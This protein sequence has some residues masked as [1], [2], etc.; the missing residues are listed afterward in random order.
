MADIQSNIQVNID[1]SEAL[2]QLKALQ[3]QIST[4]HTS[5]AKN[6][7]QAARAQQDL[8]SNLINSIN[9]T[10]KFS[11]GIREIKSTTESFTDSLER[12]KLSTREYFRFAAGSTRT[13]GKLFKSEFD[14]IGKV[15][16]ERVKT[17]Q[18]QY[19]KM[20]RSAN[21]A[22]QSI[23]VRPL[24]L[25]MQDLSTKIALAAQKQ[26]LF[27]QLLKQGSTNLLNFGKNTQWAGRQ[28]MVGFTIPLTIF[29]T[30][31]SQ[32]FMDL[33]KQ[34]IRFKRVYGEI[35]TTTE[36]T[37]AALENI[38]LLADEFTKYGVAVVDTMKL[39]ADAA[40][41]GKMGAD[42]MAQ[43]TE[44]TRLAVLGSVEQS[45]A[46]STTIALQDAFGTSA[47]DLTRKINFLNA[48]ENQTV[49]SI[50]D[51]TIAIPKAGP[52]VKQLGGDVEDLAFFL[53]A[54]KEGGINA[55][56]GAN[57][58]KS[59]LAAL[60]NP[61]E[62]A[63][64]F[65]M[66]FGVNINSIVESNQG[67][68][69][70]I[71]L[72]FAA[73]LDTLDPL[74]RARAI[75]QLF[76]KFQFSRL[77]TLFQNVS[78][79][80]T[81]A[82]RVL[83][84]VS[85]STEELAIL[86]ERELKT[87][88]DATGTRFKK[89]M[90]NLKTAIAPVGEQ[91]LKAVTPIAEFVAKILEKFNGLGDGTKKALVIV[92]TVIGAIGPVFLMTFGL[93]AN[94]AANIIKL[95]GTMRN[96]FL[97]L[98]KQS[99]Q[100]AF[101]TQYMSS[102]QIEAA[103]IAASLN[104]AHSKL[105]QTFTL[106]SSA[107]DGLTNAYRRGVVAANNFAIAN[108]GMMGS[109]KRKK[110][111]AGGFVPGSGSGDTVPAMLTPGEFVVTKDAAQ[112][113]K[114]FLQGLNKGGFVLRNGG[115]PKQSQFVGG[116]VQTSGL[117][118]ISA[119]PTHTDG[120]LA[121]RKK[122]AGYVIAG[123]QAYN[124]AT[125][126][127]K[128][129]PYPYPLTRDDAKKAIQILARGPK[130]PNTIAALGALTDDY[131]TLNNNES[132]RRG[133]ATRYAL[134]G[135]LAAGEVKPGGP[136]FRALYGSFF[137]ASG[138]NTDTSGI[139]NSLM[140]NADTLW[141]KGLLSDKGMA[142]RNNKSKSA[143]THL[144]YKT[145]MSSVLAMLQQGKGP[146]D[147]ATRGAL[148][149]LIRVD[150]R[151][152]VVGA[153]QRFQRFAANRGFSIRGMQPPNFALARKM[154]TG[155]SV[156][157]YGEKDTVPAL[158]TPGEFVVNKK[159]TQ[160]N[161]PLL[162]A[163]NSGVPVKR[164][165]GT[166]SRSGNPSEGIGINPQSAENAGTKFSNVVERSLA[167]VSSTFANTISR[168]LLGS[169]RDALNNQASMQNPVS[170]LPSGERVSAGGI[171]IPVGVKDPSEDK[172]KQATKQTTKRRFGRFGRGGGAAGGQDAEAMRVRN[173]MMM[174]RANMAAFGLSAIAQGAS[175]MGGGI[176]DKVAPMMTAASGA[177]MAMSM[178][179]G[180][181]S[182]A[183]VGIGAIALAAVLVRRSF[184]KAQDE[185]LAF[186]EQMGASSKNIRMFAEAAGKVSA[187]EVMERRRKEKT[188]IYQIQ[189][190]KKTFGQAFAEGE[191]GKQMTK[192]VGK[193]IKQSGQ[194]GAQSALVS[195]MATAV[196]SGAMSAEQAR[197][198]VANIAQ[199]LGD[200]SFGMSVNAKLISILGPSGENL[201]TD[202]LT[203]RTKLIQDTRERMGQAS[204]ATNRSSK[205]TGMDMVKA[206]GWQAA[207]AGGGALAG[208]VVG[209]MI[210]PVVGTA[211]GAVVGAIGG[212]I[213]G[214]VYGR[215]DR[216]KRMGESSG[217][218]VALQKIA[219]EQQQE[220]L[221][222]MDLEYQRKIELLKAEGKISEAKK[223]QLEYD[224]NRQKL[225]EENQKTTEQITDSFATSKAQSQ[226]MTGVDKAITRKYKGTALEDVA[227]LSKSTIDD[228]EL[229]DEQ[230]FTLKMQ[231]AS[232]QLDPMQVLDIVDIFK[233][234]ED[235]EKFFKITTKFGGAVGSEALN[236]ASMFAG[237]DGTE[238]ELS[239]KIMFEVGA[240]PTPKEAQETIDFWNKITK[241]GGVL[242]V[243]IIGNV[244]SKDVDKQARLMD[245]FKQIDAKKGKIDVKIATKMF[246]ASSQAIKTL[247]ENL[248]YYNALPAEQQ[249]IYL[250]SLIT[251]TETV[252]TNGP[253]FQA[254]LK[255][256][257]ANARQM[258]Q[259]GFIESK[260]REFIHFKSQQLTKIAGDPTSALGGGGSGGGKER[261]TIFDD[262]LMRLKMVQDRSIKATGG[263]AELKRV[264]SGKGKISL[265]KFQGVDQQLLNNGKVSQE[266]LD[267][268]DALGPEGIQKDLKQ[269]VTIGKNGLMTLNEAGKVVLR[270]FVAAKLGEYEVSIKK[271]IQALNQQK[272]ATGAL[273]KA[274]FSYAEAQEL[275]KDQTLAL[276]LANNELTPK[277][278][279]SLRAK[280]Q[281]LTKAQLHYERVTKVALMDEM[282]GQKARFEMVQK[283]VAL[284]E[285]LIENQ[286]ASEK[287]ILTSRQ[288]G[289][290]YALEKISQEEEKINEKYD[291]QIESLDKIAAKQEEI[292]Q[293]QQRRFSL[294]QALAG[295]DMAGAAGA[296][297]EIRQA[298]AAAQIERKRKAIEDSRKKQLAGIEFGG[299]TREQ[300]EADNKAI[301][302]SLSDIEEK[303][304]LAKNALDDELKKTIGM[305]RVE[306]S[307]AVAGIGAALDAGI[308]PN[309]KDFL[310]KI[311]QGVIGNATDTVTALKA[312]GT[313]IK[314]LLALQEKEKEK[315]TGGTFEDPKIKAQREAEAAAKAA[316]LAAAGG[317]PTPTPTSTPPFTDH[318]NLPTTVAPKAADDWATQM[319]KYLG[320]VGPA[321]VWG[322]KQTTP[323]P[324]PAAYNPLNYLRTPY[325]SGGMVPKYMAMGGVVP[326]Y[327]AAGGYGKGTDTIPAM[328]T[329]GEF[330]IQ[331]RAVDMLGTGVMNSINNGEVLGNSVYNYSLS[332]N[333]SNSNANP[334]DIA[335][336]VINQIKQIDSQRIRGNR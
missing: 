5:L 169:T 326:K 30:K 126:S 220:L 79:D 111:A 17:M 74:S 242:D 108:P 3:R 18:T 148:G 277:Q 84:L 46:L 263:L 280:T 319:G 205:V 271:T 16:E 28:L 218:Q 301:V 253:E 167:K 9:A 55:S 213:A 209:S 278:L 15:A 164:K 331:K 165:F 241:L 221:D 116:Q 151:G 274:G 161:G 100:L 2:A 184:D 303:I 302:T 19:I 78:K 63:S 265:T 228:M 311:L 171:I 42:L 188:G 187:G 236:V 29:G 189:P 64:A 182:A 92:A 168:A 146:K 123:S 272:Q 12:N 162:E 279:E 285:Q 245:I 214:A 294:A 90:E 58:L 206:Q 33:E 135:A 255:E 210:L 262:L 292:N 246:G 82:S 157:G 91:F 39:A 13:F 227:T 23:A 198:V 216:A 269:F 158:L 170:T 107:V 133:M 204:A 24:T 217:A 129:L 76:G 125:E 110:F 233:T 52:V 65:L 289:N 235:Q 99:N 104:Q 174:Q 320:G 181:V 328:L 298:E 309:N 86:S 121:G 128:A 73:A 109:T 66:D 202:P 144:K 229:K 196:S 186:A 325:N 283:F 324:K 211:I 297:Q 14:T 10:G 239:K 175:L 282:D 115:T 163:M 98:G 315:L 155:G 178:I 48:V 53:T 266:F 114:G 177:I 203:V 4:F 26:Q 306:I 89:S 223:L 197:S 150:S 67:N 20:G 258:E 252:D 225:V 172:E 62:K 273:V 1:A 134:N 85:Q 180:P 57:A 222:S 105:I 281:E 264:M 8:Q 215:K 27:G 201:M 81:Q 83:D 40:A 260:K 80:G 88:E 179:Q 286:Y 208:A 119:G 96:G 132:W 247:N 330:V 312:V 160:E 244:I 332:V 56:E 153:S 7:A 333:V 94:G 307:A 256:T 6:S 71:V 120:P 95:F 101:Q 257:G 254:Y 243:S 192:D 60:I 54:M 35:F 317:T 276:A 49:V 51:L 261:V 154:A 293:I 139:R 232:G 193:N 25:D 87:V 194:A 124:Q 212:A 117:H 335:R 300:I 275:S 251:T 296:I 316:A 305:T 195:Q 240:A 69:K 259:K 147:L 321:P 199:E 61:T 250:T 106:E 295:G 32:V 140:Q 238:T 323:K 93:I 31:A 138:T 130:T 185:T 68:V 113:N 159:A 310:G 299:K 137:R 36:E 237:K 72:D 176:A 11:A 122:Y 44:A 97:G 183:V 291:K 318:L 327:F 313:E 322:A 112:D 224:T 248:D 329:P 226:L 118:L 45:E 136:I 270:A 43:V 131:G 47:E 207:G 314:T 75:E 267:F 127:N 38:R 336:T 41:S 290:E 21:G 268:L 200:A 143:G 103:T 59:G 249:K 50:E 334:N 22:L 231:L 37:N 141:K 173:Q 77:S 284:Q 190:G 166:P 287:A 145:S 219:L 70:G 149:N 142:V 230:K 191:Q 152:N 308:D 288:E 102:E 34:A 304:R 156:P 234:K